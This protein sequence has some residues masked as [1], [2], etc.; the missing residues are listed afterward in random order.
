MPPDHTL[1]TRALPPGNLKT[2]STGKPWDC[3]TCTHSI[4]HGPSHLWCE[5]HKVVVINPCARWER[6]AGCDTPE[7]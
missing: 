6:G 1:P 5:F 4:G 7:G 3:R 2:Y